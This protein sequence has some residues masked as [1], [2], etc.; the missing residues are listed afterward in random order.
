[1]GGSRTA[2]TG[3]VRIHTDR[4]YDNAVYVVGHYDPFVQEDVWV[5]FR[6]PQLTIR[7]F[8]PI[9]IRVHFAINN[10]PE[11]VRPVLGA[12]GYEIR[13]V[14]RVIVAFQPDRPAPVSA[15]MSHRGPSIGKRHPTH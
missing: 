12:N 7:D 1:L 8:P 2:P 11:D 15:C 10:P 5:L 6:Q 9:G 4:D 14:S 3:F 13:A